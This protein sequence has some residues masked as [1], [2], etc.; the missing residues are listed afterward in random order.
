MKRIITAII[1]ALLALTVSCEKSIRFDM[2]TPEDRMHL[3]VSA[4]SVEV[5]FFTEGNVITFTWGDSGYTSDGI[6]CTY[7][8]KM[9]VAGNNFET[10]IS[11]IDVS[12][13]HEISFDASFLQSCLAKWKVSNGT[14]V[15]L[16]AEVIA[17]PIE[18]GPISEQN[19][20]KPEVSK[21]EFDVVCTDEL[22][23]VI[24]G[25]ENFFTSNILYAVLTQSGTIRCKSGENSYKD[26]TVPEA[27]L[28]WF[29]L[30]YAN[31][32]VNMGRPQLWILGDATDNG[33]NLGSMPEFTSDEQDSAIK[34]WH[35]NLKSGELKFPLAQNFEWNFNIPYLMPAENGT[36]AG[37]GSVIYVPKGSPDN[38]WVVPSNRTGEYEITVDMRNMTVSFNLINFNYILKW[39][40]I[41]MVGSATTGGWESQPFQIQLTYD[42]S[43]SLKGHPGVFYY[44]GPLTEG[45]FKFPLEERTFEVPYLMPKNVGENGLASL[46]GDGETCEIEY[47]ERYG[48]DHKW[49]VSADQAGNYL[50]VVD[51]DEMNMTVHKK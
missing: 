33:W 48:D 14:K 39:E 6:L 20:V 38:K 12:G 44:E 21:V 45:E 23:L 26:I 28:W 36:P 9:D 3:A 25:V 35:G 27:G 47:V 2:P 41:W 50:L 29:G 11:N 5:A 16:E 51:T 37:D 32:T 13:K 1:P 24:E 34:K 19:Y 22:T 4:E 30:D 15:R 42:E 43:A 18:T 10:S 46:P 31:R 8:F 40:N 7:S 49:V 17:A